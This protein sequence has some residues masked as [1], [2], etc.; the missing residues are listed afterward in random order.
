MD[1]HGL[2]EARATEIAKD[3]LTEDPK[4]YSTE[5]AA[6]EAG[7]T[8]RHQVVLPVGS[9]LDPGPSGTRNVGKIKVRDQETGK[10]KWRSVRAGLVMAPDG[11]P[12]SSR[13]PGG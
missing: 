7:K 13:N 4:Y 10:T 8:G 12:T 2:D 9:Q 3:H 5:K 11:T 6:L 1:E